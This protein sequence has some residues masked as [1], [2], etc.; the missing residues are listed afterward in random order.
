M[1][2]WKPYAGAACVFVVIAGLGWWVTGR[3][4][5]PEKK[6]A[7]VSAP[8]TPAHER[9]ALEEQ[10]KLKPGHAPV[11]LRLAQ[12]DLEQN[13]PAEAA[14]RLEQLLR[15]DPGHQ[16]ARL[17]LGRALYTAGEVEKARQVT[18]E[19]LKVNPAQPDALYNL[20]A[21]HANQGN[22]AR[23]REYWSKAVQAAPDSDSGRKAAAALKQL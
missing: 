5:A 8:P 16:E 18:E 12:L 20:G 23:A 15:Q 13:R 17:E 6:A 11:V 1:S 9:A 3:P 2:R 21:I 22:S 4:K 14:S 19:I 7:P 10:L